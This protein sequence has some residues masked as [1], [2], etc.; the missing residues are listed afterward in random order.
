[1]NLDKL[2]LAL[3]AALEN[4]AMGADGSHDVHHARRVWANAQELARR[5][6]EGRTA[7]LIAAAYLHDVVNLPKNDPNR[8]RASRLSAEAAEP[9]LHGLEY[10]NE[11][12]AA[13]QHV[14]ETHSFS[15][16]IA[17]RTIEARIL[18]DADR[19]EALGALGIARTF[20]VAGL[21]GSRLFDG[22]DPFAETRN[23]DDEAFSV[24]HFSVKLLRLPAA[25]QT[26]SGKAMAEERVVYMRGFLD[27][28][29]REIGHTRP[30]DDCRW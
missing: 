29:G 15:A 18:Q 10:G 27:Q 4:A 12:I 26:A 3:E 1:M 30:A 21:L 9:I 5:E 8:A 2:A 28:L 13:I 24:D 7:I 22:D 14:I 25:M 11:D 20:Y 16:G 6:G 23:L 17:P 19:L